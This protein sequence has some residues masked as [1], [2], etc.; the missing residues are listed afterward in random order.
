MF[1]VFILFVYLSISGDRF[2]SMIDDAWWTGVLELQEPLSLAFA[3]SLFQCFNVRWD[4]GEKEK[5]SPWD[6]E[7]YGE[8][9]G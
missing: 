4:N 2:R 3:D 1:Y 5:M 6:L 8:D 9:D 7:P